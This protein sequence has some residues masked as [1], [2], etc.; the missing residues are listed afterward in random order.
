MGKENGMRQ[1]WGDIKRAIFGRSFLIA[2][3]GMVLCLLIGAFSDALSVFRM[4]ERHVLYGYHRELLLNALGS[5][6]ILFAV[7]ILA[8]IP[9]TTAFT[10]DVKSGYLKPYLTRTSVTRYILGKG[11]GAAVSGGLALV[12]GILT[13][14]GIFM[15]VFSPMEVYGEYAVESKIPDIV[16][17]CFLFFLSGAMW[18]SVGLL[19]S[20]LTQN[21]YLAYAAPFIFYYVLIILQERYFRTT[22]MLNPKNYLTMQGAWPLEGKSAA[23]TLLMLVL[24]LQ[25]VF[26]MTA[27]TELRDD[28]RQKKHYAAQDFWQ[29]M[30]AKRIERAKPKRIRKENHVLYT[31]SQVG[32]VVRYNFRMWRGNVRIVLTFALAFILCF[33]L[34]DKAAS[35]AYDMGT[36]MQAF[37]P[38]V[39]TFGDAN[40]VLLI[41]LLL[42]LLFADIPFLGAGVPY[43]LVRMKRSTWAWGQ[44]VY[45]ILATLIYMFFIFVATTLICM[46]NSFIGNMWSETA[47]ILGYSGAGKAVALPALV[48]T[49]E[50][51]RP[52]QCA[53]T[54]FLLMLLYTLVLAL[55]MLF[56]KL[57]RG[58]SAG[59]VAAFGFSLY[60][61]LLNP[62]LIKKMFNLP[63]EL[64]YKANVAVGW[65]SPLNQATY[66]MHNFGYD[67]LPR[68]WQ[69]YLIF[70]A[71]IAGLM[72]GILRAIRKYNFMFLGTEQ[73]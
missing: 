44:L 21:V 1:I 41:S 16:L 64:M 51:S 56:M 40:S 29:K 43:Y 8:A 13:A 24:I 17:R 54:I 38:F 45:L 48:K 67:L 22:F 59:V 57:L 5:D 36:A 32:A 20:S 35:F 2:F 46:Q 58:K 69:T 37:E 62:Q 12:L 68:L 6:I 70:L 71:V 73:S 61:L 28:K 34:S 10:D 66:H 11:I 18:A 47:A 60:G 30:L 72:F 7:P 27:Q 49:L 3:G 63:D 53:A 39:W 26:Y 25:L 31:L 52:Y 65:L 50:M 4:E 14:L 15:L 42:V 9:Y 19:C 23:L 33:L 55:L